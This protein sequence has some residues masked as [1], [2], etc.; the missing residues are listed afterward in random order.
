[1]KRD[2]VFRYLN[3]IDSCFVFTSCHEVSRFLYVAGACFAKLAKFICLR[4]VVVV[5]VVHREA[6]L[7]RSD[8]P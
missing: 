3:S 6:S 5:V 1:M 7:G 4:D 2:L 8:A